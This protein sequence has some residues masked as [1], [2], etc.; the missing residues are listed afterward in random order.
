MNGREIPGCPYKRSIRNIPDREGR[1]PGDPGYEVGHG[2]PPFELLL[3]S[4]AMTVDS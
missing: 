1:Y 3:G 2:S 4:F